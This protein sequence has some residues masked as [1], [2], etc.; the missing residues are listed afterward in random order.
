MG[1]GIT[2][3][4]A[5]TTGSGSFLPQAAR[6]AWGGEGP[7]KGSADSASLCLQVGVVGGHAAQ[8]QVVWSEDGGPSAL[9]RGRI[10]ISERACL[11]GG[12]GV[13]LAP[14]ISSMESQDP[15][16]PGVTA[17]L[18][19]P[20]FWQWEVHCPGPSPVP[21]HQHFTA[22]GQ[23]FVRKYGLQCSKGQDPGSSRDPLGW[24][25]DST[26]S[27]KLRQEATAEAAGTTRKPPG[28]RS[29]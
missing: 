9:A 16:A 1:A 10:Q 13:T 3:G 17:R 12:G 2:K 25:D 5:P 29:R 18:G 15:R 28:W 6:L 24:G 23:G 8:G 7:S 21:P 20:S 27:L 19:Q 11:T 4:I 26:Q 22:G 14:G